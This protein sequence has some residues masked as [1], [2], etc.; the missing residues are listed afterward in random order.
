TVRCQV[1]TTGTAAAIGTSMA[2]PHAAGV[3]VLFWS[4]AQDLVGDVTATRAILDTTARDVSDLRCGGTAGDNNVWGQ[5]RIDAH[6]AVALATGGAPPPREPVADFTF[7]CVKSGGTRTCTFDGSASVG[8]IV[9][10]TWD[11][12]DGT[13]GSGEV[14]THR[15]QG[16]RD[17]DVTLTVTDA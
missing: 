2:S 16:G 10:W 15:Y 5:G 7:G 1:S 12:D 8:D 9:S 3:L 4:A 17:R 11:F 14:V 13:T 6:A